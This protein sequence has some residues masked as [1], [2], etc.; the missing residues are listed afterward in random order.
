MNTAWVIHVLA[1]TPLFASRAFQP[2]FVTAALARWGAQIPWLGETEVMAALS[3]APHWF[4]HDGT[5]AVLGILAVLEAVAVKNPDLRRG[6]DYIDRIAKVALF[7]VTEL[8]L[9]D[10]AGIGIAEQLLRR[11]MHNGY[12]FVLLIFETYSFAFIY[13]KLIVI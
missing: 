9:L 5:I 2:A 10:A 11:N 8:A 3:H 7:L 4:T 1:S 13:K 12:C 6:M